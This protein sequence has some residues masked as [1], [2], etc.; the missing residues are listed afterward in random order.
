MRLRIRLFSIYKD[1]VGKQDL[2]LNIEKGYRVTDVLEMLINMYPKLKEMFNEVPPVIFMN[3]EVVDINTVIY[4][5]SEVAIAPPAS[6]GNNVKVRFFEDDVSVDKVVE[7]ITQEGVGAIAVFVG[8]V[9]DVVDGRRVYELSYEAYTPYALKLLERIAL[10]E[11]AKHGV[12]S[13]QIHHRIGSTKPRQKTIVI[14][15][16]AKGRKEALEALTAI[17][18]RVKKEAP[19]YK[20]EKREDGDFWVVGDGKRVP[21]ARV[22]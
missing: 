21:R 17:L 7:E 3:G 19:I 15:V 16:A 14:A 20:L 22:V 18:E 8:I 11:L 1:V 4:E 6:G 13:V 12:S 2:E 9:K 10:E 5:E